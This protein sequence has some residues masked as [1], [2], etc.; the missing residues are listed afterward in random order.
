[1]T[2]LL[3]AI[4]LLLAACALLLG[5]GRDPVQ[6]R[7]DEAFSAALARSRTDP[8]GAEAALVALADDAPRAVDAGFA[9]REIVRLMLDGGRTLEAARLLEH[10]AETA[11]RQDDRARAYYELAR[12]AEDEGD[13]P[14]AIRLYRSLALHYPDLMPGERAL[15]HL[16]RIARE[17][18]RAAVDAH[19]GWTRSVSER[20]AHTGLADDLV[21]QA[22]DEARL[23][24]HASGDAADQALAEEL[25]GRLADG[26]QTPLWNDAVWE[27]SWLYHE[28][29]RHREEAAALARILRTREELS[30]F[31]QDEHPYYWQGQLRL[32]RL[33]LVELGEPRAAI[34][35]YLRYAELFPRTI[36]KDDVRFFA[37]CASLQAGERARADALAALLG[38]EHPDSKYLRRLEPAFADPRGPHCLPPEVER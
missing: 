16:L 9:R 3:A 37:L 7:W 19:L 6:V 20:L 34:D 17:E 22:A 26:P 31:G 29:G 23:R 1:M 2:R 30:L 36:K 13:R 12:L 15:A 24:A 35:A 27:L 14:T 10:I 33:H 18:G 38:R 25:F 28:Q 11:P 5:C 4:A 21:F 32:A 8:A